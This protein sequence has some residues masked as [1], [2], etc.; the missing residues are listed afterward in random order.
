MT[1]LA[2]RWAYDA[3]VEDKAGRTLLIQSSIFANSYDQAYS[4]ASDRLINQGAKKIVALWLAQYKE[5]K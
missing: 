5:A 4:G 2:P 3:R 1:K